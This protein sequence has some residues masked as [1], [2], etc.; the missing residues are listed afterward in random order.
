MFNGRGDGVACGE[1]GVDDDSE[2]FD[3]EVSFV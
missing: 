1:W 2:A 3:L